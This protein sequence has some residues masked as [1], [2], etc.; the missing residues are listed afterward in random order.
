LLAGQEVRVVAVGDDYTKWEGFKDEATGETAIGCSY[1]ALCS[2]V[3]EGS[4]ILC[5]DG[6]LTLQVL[7]VIT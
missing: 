7:E 4:L 3:H 1:A 2:S 6:T 5:A